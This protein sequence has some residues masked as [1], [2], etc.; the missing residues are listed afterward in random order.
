MQA[1]AHKK[2]IAVGGMFLLLCL[3]YC[4]FGY[5]LSRNQTT[6]LLL[7]FSGL[8]LFSWPWLRTKTTGYLALTKAWKSDLLTGI[9]LRIL[10]LF[11]WPNL[12]QD[13]YRFLWDGALFAQ[14]ISP[15]L[16]TPEALVG[17]QDLLNITLPDRD[18][19][20]RLMGSLSAG[21]F[22]NYPPIKQLIFALPQ[23]LNIQELLYRISILRFVIILCDVGVF[24]F[25]RRLLLTLGLN[26]KKINWYYLNPLVILELT[27]NCHFEGIMAL[28]LLGGLLLL[29]NKKYLISGIF[30]AIGVG[31]KLIPLMFIPLV[32]AFIARQ[33]SHGNRVI[34]LLKFSIAI[35]AT[36]GIIF[37]PFVTSETAAHY[38]AT[39]GLWFTKFEFNASLYYILRWIG[40]QYKGYNL[41][42]Q[43]GPALS[44]LSLMIILYLAYRVF[45]KKT[46][47]WTAVM[48]SLIVYLLCATTVHP[49]YWI[50]VLVLSVFTESRIGILGSF[51][52]FLSYTAY[53]QDPVQEQTIWL[54]AEYLLL[55]AYGLWEVSN[56]KAPKQ[57][58][59]A[60]PSG[61]KLL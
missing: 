9:I 19:I 37:V 15:Y 43:I 34:P 7:S 35:I 14:G 31:I 45:E 60:I 30:F 25:G 21:N 53:G 24:F 52:M 17:V 8:W 12:S 29:I 51:L 59:D 49:W 47:L 27:G 57:I 50:T 22:S 61:N 32:L 33:L 26:Q 44:L 23:W 5:F 13:V 56:S 58:S 6:L 40:F 42:A 28:S 55:I 1:L 38:Q 3:G 4:G 41:I 10:L 36:L 11:S 46:D 20:L 18:Q 48:W 39:T 2:S 16:Y 54:F